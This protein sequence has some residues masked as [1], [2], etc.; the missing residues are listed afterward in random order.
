[1]INSALSKNINNQLL[2]NQL[3]KLLNQRKDNLLKEIFLQES[4]NQFYKSY[5]AFREKY[6]DAKWSIQ[7][8]KNDKNKSLLDIKIRSRREINNQINRIFISLSPNA[9]FCFKSKYR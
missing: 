3:E 2:S 9:Q 7:P 1:M 4:F 5:K 8:V 6:K